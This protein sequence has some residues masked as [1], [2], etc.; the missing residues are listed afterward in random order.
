MNI[1]AQSHKSVLFILQT[2]RVLKSLGHPIRL[3]MVK[4]LQD[5]ERTVTEIQLHLGLEQA[6]TSQ[7]LRKMYKEGIV[8]FRREGT[9]YYYSLANEFIQVL[10]NCFAGCEAKIQSGEWSLEEMGIV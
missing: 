1:K 5:G 6:I 10:I 2:S 3:E 7:H 4:Y 9:T 8:T